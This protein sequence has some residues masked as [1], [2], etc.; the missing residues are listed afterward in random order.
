MNTANVVDASVAVKL[1]LNEPLAAEAAALFS[2]LTATPPAVLSVPDLFYPEC[3]N[4][5]WKHC[6]RGNCSPAQATAFM[7]ALRSL[8]LQRLPTF[9][10]SSDA[11]SLALTH[12]LSAYDACYV[13]LA[14]RL[15]VPLITA[16]QRLERKMAGTPQ[17][18]IWLGH[19]SPPPPAPTMAVP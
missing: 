14:N 16:D 9:D 3:A 4:I 13:A 19:W 17:T 2:Q 15:G 8:P 18:V 11:L 7:A 10:F 6:Q 12:N 5:F 1:Y